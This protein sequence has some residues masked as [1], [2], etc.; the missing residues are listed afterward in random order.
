MLPVS[1]FGWLSYAGLWGHL[2]LLLGMVLLVL[3]AFGFVTRSRRLAVL[4]TGFAFC[5]V[6]A[7]LGAFFSSLFT[8]F[9]QIVRNPFPTAQDL[10]AGIA[11]G[12]VGPLLAVFVMLV[13]VPTA[14]L[15]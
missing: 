3:L 5:P 14:F 1:C 7:I 15:L 6:L 4:C 12:C 11:V 9:G 8:G 13:T 10:C 2:S